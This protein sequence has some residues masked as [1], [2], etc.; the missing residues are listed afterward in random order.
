LKQFD[1]AIEWARRSIA[2]GPN[3]SPRTQGT[4]TAALALTG[5]DAE[6]QE[7]LQGY[8]ALPTAGPKTIAA[9]KAFKA[10]DTN[11]HSDP[12]FGWD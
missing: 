1:Q 6:A 4:L 11:E 7:A 2:I 8:L 9:W 3:N 12:R 5:H 10:Q